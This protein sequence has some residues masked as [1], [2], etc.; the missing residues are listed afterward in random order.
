MI[1][2]RSLLVIILIII[3]WRLG[4]AWYKR[5]VKNQQPKNQ[6]SPLTQI[7]SETML[8]CDYCGVYL[9]AHEAVREGNKVYCCH[10]HKRMMNSE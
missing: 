1:S 9:P 3:I 7:K 8:R 5:F 6:S 4:Q 2:L 10:A